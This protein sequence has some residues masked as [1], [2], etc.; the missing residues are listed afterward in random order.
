M[1]STFTQKDCYAGIDIG[2]TYLRAG[3]VSPEGKI[4][5][6]RLQNVQHENLT[7][8]T[9][10]IAAQIQELRQAD[11]LPDLLQTGQWKV[12]LRAETDSN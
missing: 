3:I 4:Q 9:K 2:A 6:Q 5:A 12:E 11:V 7:V 1:S 10:Q 8:L